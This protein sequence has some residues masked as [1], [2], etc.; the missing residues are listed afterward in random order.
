MAFLIENGTGSPLS[1]DDLGI[2]LEVGETTELA[3]RTQPQEVALTSRN[4]RV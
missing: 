1:I 2:T 3:T 4:E